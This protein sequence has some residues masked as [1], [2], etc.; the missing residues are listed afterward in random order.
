MSSR[1]GFFDD[2]VPVLFL[3]NVL[4]MFY[5][6]AVADG[7]DRTDDR[8]LRKEPEPCSIKTPLLKLSPSE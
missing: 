7:T 6:I 5:F 8:S 3:T 4:C 1:D 2:Y